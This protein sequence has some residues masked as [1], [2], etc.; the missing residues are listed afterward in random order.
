M[1]C[2]ISHK[3]ILCVGS[4]LL[5][6]SQTLAFFDYYDNGYVSDLNMDSW[7]Q[8][9]KQTHK[10][11]CVEIPDNMKLCKNIGYKEMRLP[12]LLD[13][14]SVAEA[15]DQARV[16]V[17]LLNLHC[18]PD[19]QLFL[20]SLYAPVCLDPPVEPCRSLCEGVK[21]GCEER[22]N[23]YGYPWPEILQCDKFDKDPC[24]QQVNF[25]EPAN[26]CEPCKKPLTFESLLDSYCWSDKVIKVKIKSVENDANGDK[27]IIF[28][29]KMKFY[30][31]KPKHLTRQEIESTELVIRKGAACDCQ[32]AEKPGKY[33]LVM[34]S[35]TD[36][37]H[38]I[39]YISDWEKDKQFKRAVRAMR[40]GHDCKLQIEDIPG[41]DATGGLG[42]NGSQLP[43]ASTDTDD[44]KDKK[45]KDKKKKGKDKKDKKDKKDDSDPMAEIAGIGC[46]PCKQPL[47]FENLIE[48]YC[49]AHFVMKT[50]VRKV[51]M[52][53]N[54]D[55][56]LVVK[57]LKAK[58]FYKQET[59][60]KRDIRKLQPVIGGG[61]DCDCTKAAKGNKL[62]IMGRK[63]GIR[64]VINF[65]SEDANDSE[66]K[67]FLRAIRKG[68]D[69]SGVTSQV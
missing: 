57:K 29:G 39:T 1:L 12:N 52:D 61:S 69:C 68:Y 20:C 35:V 4:V 42:I 31:P 25:E 22:M 8:I 37:K 14:E 51:K 13:H 56:R 2:D 7:Q 24:I 60:T 46:I 58:D 32:P 44:D 16:W 21:R 41:T 33:S 67:R 17:P 53:P 59:L 3:M 47:V 64:Y 66:F 55:K 50:K 30:K 62:F 19:T 54:G 65:L 11:K 38:D 40:K 27:R 10:P 49:D 28:K 6:V 45:K 43:T 26:V 23:N 15:V 5:F 48:K 9:G 63:E 18:H 34:T 36:G